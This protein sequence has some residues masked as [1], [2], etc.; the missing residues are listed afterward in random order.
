MEKIEFLLS[1]YVISNFAYIVFALCRDI[2]WIKNREKHEELI[3]YNSTLIDEC[4]RF[5]YETNKRIEL[6][7]NVKV[8]QNVENK[9]H[10]S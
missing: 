5:I 9:I 8:K 3:K 10:N 2:Y 6:I 7:E 1:F 4:N